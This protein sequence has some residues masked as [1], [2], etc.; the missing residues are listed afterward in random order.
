MPHALRSARCDAC[1]RLSAASR[2]LADGCA[3][4]AC[5][6]AAALLLP[7]APPVI[8]GLPCPSPVVNV[9]S[10][11]ALPAAPGTYFL[12]PGAYSVGAP[13]SLAGASACYVGAGA[14][15]A[16]VVLQ[17]AHK[18]DVFYLASGAAALGLQGLTLSGPGRDSFVT[19]VA[20]GSD[21][22]QLAV[23]DVA[24]QGL[25]YGINCRA[26]SPAALSLV[27]VAFAD[28]YYNGVVLDPSAA[29]SY[30]WRDVSRSLGHAVPRAPAACAR[31]C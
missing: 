15:R 12:A 26:A 21:G 16:D 23:Q 11:G 9:T 1:P 4:P 3:L 8:N 18:F 30:A 25:R 24:M 29:R 10:P 31:S 27:G 22:A 14:S 2:R 7:Q 28:I 19:A 17:I 13:I 5:A 20:F 6:R